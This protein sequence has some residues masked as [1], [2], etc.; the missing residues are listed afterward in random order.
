MRTTVAAFVV[1]L[2][3]ASAAAAGA[4][5]P[6]RY[7]VDDDPGGFTTPGYVWIESTFNGWSAE[8]YPL[9]GYCRYA[10]YPWGVEQLGCWT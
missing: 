5:P 4:R 3:L 2:A 9:F 8:G 10:S 6:V 7:S 1:L